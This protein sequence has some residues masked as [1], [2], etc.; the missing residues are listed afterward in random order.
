M[1]TRQAH[2]RRAALSVA[3]D[4]LDRVAHPLMHWA[5]ACA[6]PWSTGR[7]SASLSGAGGHS[8]GGRLVSTSST[9]NRSTNTT[10]APS[11]ASSSSFLNTTNTAA[12]AGA[13]SSS[14]LVSSL[15][16][17]HINPAIP[18]LL[19]VYQDEVIPT[20]AAAAEATQLE[21]AMRHALR[22]YTAVSNKEQHN[23][24][25]AAGGDGGAAAG[26]DQH[27]SKSTHQYTINTT[28][29]I[30]GG[31]ATNT[32]PNTTTTTH[33]TTKIT[34]TT[35][36]PMLPMSLM[37]ASLWRGTGLEVL[38]ALCNTPAA[39]QVLREAGAVQELYMS[40]LSNGG[41]AAQRLLVRLVR[42][43]RGGGG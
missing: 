38:D 29:P 43:E 17:G 27:A 39:A 26:D 19:A 20:H 16:M 15:P 2:S 6:I 23:N 25:P 5:T 3:L 33:T 24:A 12:A 7:N 36:M 21:V 37:E 31:P 18:A 1:Q 11:A 10:T 32:T 22:M 4:H 30:M 28:K 42:N 40:N 35:N 8:T 14:S 41:G 9:T 13:A 34:T